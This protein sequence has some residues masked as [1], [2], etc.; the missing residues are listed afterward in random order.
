MRKVDCLRH[1]YVNE[2]E[3]GYFGGLSSAKRRALS[4]DQ[5]VE[6]ITE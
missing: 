4:F 1:A 3:G 6:L 2:I 5:A